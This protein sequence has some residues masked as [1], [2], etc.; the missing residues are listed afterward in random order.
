M[1]YR[2]ALEYIENCQSVGIVPGLDSIRELLERLGNPQKELRIVHV[3]GTNGKGSVSEM[4]ASV[5]TAGGY[6]IGRYISPTI[7]DYRERIQIG[8]KM[9][10]KPDLGKYMEI[11]ADAAEAM[12]KEGWPHPSPFEIETALGFLYFRD[13]K[14]DLVML[15]AGLGGLE[16]ATNVIDTPLLAVITSISRDHMAFLGNSIAEIAVQKAGILKEGG[17]AVTLRQPD[18]AMAVLEKKAEEAGCTLKTADPD[19]AYG[20]KY[21]LEIQKFSY[22]NWKD[23]E[24]HLAGSYQIDNAV[25]ALEALN[26]L[27]HLGFPVSEEKLRKGFIEAQWPGRFQLIHKKPYFIVDGAHNAD[28]AAR[29]ADSL[30]FHFKKEGKEKPLIYIM[31]VFRDKEYE[32]IIQSLCPMAEQ[33]ITIQTPGSPRALP[34]YELACAVREVNPN[35]TAAD[36]LKEAVEMAWLLAGNQGVIA[37]FGSLAFQGEMMKLVAERADSAK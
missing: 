17:A 26:S 1:R 8:K 5:L 2:D 12:S 14:C 37:A 18:E 29:L 10:S 32:A 7:S 27:S 22:G 25:L 11:T 35:V 20:I 13:K 3:A 9:I 24:I 28:A 33:I 15:E 19:M 31:G 30:K 21:G 34:A 4:M 6:R 23:M 36:S 16:D